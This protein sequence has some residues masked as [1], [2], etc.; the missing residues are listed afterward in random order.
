MRE[1]SPGRRPD[2][3]GRFFLPGPTEVRP[4]ILE[5]QVGA[6]VGHRGPEIEELVESLQFGLQELFRTERPVFISASSATGLME[7]G[8]RNGASDR[9]LCLVNGAFSERF[10]RIGQ[11]CGLRVD[12]VEVPWGHH[13][14]PDDL[15]RRLRKTRYDA[16]TVVHSETSTGVLQPLEALSWVVHG[17]RD[18]MF[19]VDSVSGVGGAPLETDD[20]AVDFVLAGSQKA[21]ALPPGL[22]FC[23]ASDR[24][25]ERSASVGGKGVYFDLMAFQRKM[26]RFQT[27]N[28]PAVT[29]LY[30]LHAQLRDMLHEGIEARWQRHARMARACWGWVDRMREER[31]LELS[32]LAPAGY[33]SPTVTCIRLP[34]N[35]GG[36]GVVR[37]MRDRGFVIGS[38][39]GKLKNDTVRIGHMGDHTEAEL[40]RLLRTLEEVLAG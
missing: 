40:G 11:A 27:P 18:T 16:V 33:R 31:G 32:V 5:A 3:F 4:E 24:M 25:M 30:A 8:V 14:D 9:I 37:R 13:H 15:E 26:E 22:A 39:Y 2:L 12:R 28:T 7:A 21:M 23:V 29:L 6:V 34:G 19:L 38:G 20:W 35:V 36:P 10:A 17:F 1:T